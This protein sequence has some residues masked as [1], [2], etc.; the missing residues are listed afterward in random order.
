MLKT[1]VIEFVKYL[2]ILVNMIEKDKVDS[3]KYKSIKK[4]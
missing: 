3:N 1:I 2:L 4:K